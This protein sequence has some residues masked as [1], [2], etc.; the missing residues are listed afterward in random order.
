MMRRLYHGSSHIVDQP[1]Y[2]YENDD[3]FVH[4]GLQN[5]VVKRVVRF[6]PC[7]LR[8]RADCPRADWAV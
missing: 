8:I 4:C 7:A 1:K 3:V 6:L 2:G 5:R